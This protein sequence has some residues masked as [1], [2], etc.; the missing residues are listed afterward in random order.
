[1]RTVRW[2]LAAAGA[3]ALALIGG[4]TA[5]AA[6][7]AVAQRA[8]A[9]AVYVSPSTA[10]PGTQLRITA[11]CGSG[12][13]ASASSDLPGMPG[14][15]LTPGYGGVS[16]V[17]EVPWDTRTGKYTI[18]VVCGNADNG[19][20]TLWVVDK[21]VPSKGPHTGGG[22]TAA[23]NDSG[24]QGGTITVVGGVV[25]MTAGLGLLLVRR[26]RTG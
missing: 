6:P 19:N 3:G 12:Q 5:K 7:E 2:M 8:K 17:T 10:T 20:T 9:I 18:T 26:R 24:V 25:A 16:G 13:S 4:V 14:V 11:F 1:M 23:G 21:G 22:G 15:N